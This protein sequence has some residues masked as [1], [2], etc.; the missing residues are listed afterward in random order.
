MAFC[1]LL[2][3]ILSRKEMTGRDEDFDHVDDDGDENHEDDADNV[4]N[5]ETNTTTGSWPTGFN[6]I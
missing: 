3:P 4:A 5:T 6:T 2:V 1:S